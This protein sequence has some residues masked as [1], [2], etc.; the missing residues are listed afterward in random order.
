METD[1]QSPAK[2]PPSEVGEL[3]PDPSRW[4]TV[5]GV[6]SI[7]LASLGLAGGCCG[8]A[9]PF[10]S[11]FFLDMAADGG[12]MSAEQIQHMRASQ[13]PALWVIPA[14]LIGLALSTLLL[15]AA[16]GILRRRSSGATLCKV[17][18]WINIPWAAIS[19]IASVYIQM[20][21]P[22]DSQQMGAGF[23]YVFL[24]F[25]ICFTLLFGLGFPLFLL[26][27]FSRATIKQEVDAW[28]AESRAMI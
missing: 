28:E 3:P 17:W 4:P 25:G 15:L 7:I 24:A 11:S 16:I 20:R 8:M 22:Q 26:L 9:S 6:S 13:P 21:V 10:I 12:Q 2:T 23:Q 5:I 14:S 19:M 1:Q 18:A 27:W